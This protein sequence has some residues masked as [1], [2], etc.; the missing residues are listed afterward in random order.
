MTEGNPSIQMCTL[1]CITDTYY[2]HEGDDKP[3]VSAC[4]C[5]ACKGRQRQA[6]CLGAHPPAWPAWQALNNPVPSASLL[7]AALLQG[8]LLC[9]VTAGARVSHRRCLSRKRSRRL[10]KLNIPTLL[11]PWRESWGWGSF[12]AFYFPTMHCVFLWP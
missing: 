7:H 6:G 4:T 2:T 1:T 10:V 8:Q 3:A 5:G 12:L 11:L 9:L